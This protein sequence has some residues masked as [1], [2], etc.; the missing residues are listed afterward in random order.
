MVERPRLLELVE[1]GTKRPL[2]LIS[3]PAGSGKTVL[4]RAWIEAAE[5]PEKI[6]HVALGREHADRRTFWIDVMQAVSAARPE[7]AGLAVPAGGTRPLTDFLFELGRLESPLVIVLDDFHFV[8][9]GAVVSDIQWLLERHHPALRLVIATRHDPPL[10]LLRLRVAEEL[11]EIRGA[12]LAF[13]E[14]ETGELLAGVALASADV[15]TLWE[16]TEGWAAALK[17]A[18]LSLQTHPD[19][20]AFVE[21]FAGDDRAVTDYLTTEVLSSYDDEALGFLLRISIV[22]RINAELAEAL[23]GVADGQRSLRDLERADG[24]VDG[25]DSRGSWYRLHPLLAEV[26]RA[27]A[28]H[29]LADE[30]PALHTSASLWLADHGEPLE[31]VRHAVAAPDWQLAAE[32][33]GEQWL[34]CMLNG[35]G[36]SLRQLARQIPDD[37]VRADA[38]LALAMAGLL[39]EAGDIEHADELLLTAYEVAD[40]LSPTRSHRFNVTATATALYRARLDGDVDEALSAARLAL[41]ERWDRSV[42]AE[43]RA[44]TL[45]N[46][47]IAEFW[48]GNFDQAL[49]RL[50]AAAGLALEFGCDYVVLMA[51]SYLAA[52]DAREGRLS[53]AHS[54]A[55]TAIQLAD[56]RG[57]AEVPHVAVAHV[58]LA[59]VH[60]WWNELDEAEGAADRA[61]ETLGRSAEPLLAPLVAQLRARLCTM[62]GDA[63]TGLE[64]LRGGDRAPKLPEWLR[65]SGSFVEAELWLA[66]GEPG[67]ARRCLESVDS[68]GL[69][70]AAV[71]MA[72]LEL[73]R[74]E[75]E[76]ALR[77]IA[78]FL[79]DDREA[80]MPVTR[81]EAWTI[82]AIARDAIHDE[83]GA[84][85]AIERALDLAEPRGFTNSIIR[86]GPPV[87]S[88]LR[89]RIANGTAHRAFAAEILSVLEE[90]PG[91]QRPSAQPLL[92][93]LSERE[94]VVLRFLPTLMSNAEIAGEMF[95][96]VN[97]VKTHL[98]HIYRKLD[99]S[100]RREAVRRGRE[101]H[102]LSPGLGDQ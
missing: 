78:G 58:A 45:A 42:A 36:G 77:E 90:K 31:A 2:T 18:E 95:V 10:R 56:R 81:T 65:V 24:F 48:A 63:V 100:D 14:P 88:L 59:S 102:L 29:R 64:V 101:L 87:R 70:D 22:E 44:L 80:L 5:E 83:P 37:I 38:E 50:Q 84:L 35:L 46:L 91:S 61:R 4:L 15:Q 49:D 51:E 53:D 32:L 62:R 89:R 25:L 52:V 39:L 74:G 71:G 30:L 54:R 55:R 41:R 67:R 6:A 66:L 13:T 19:P 68:A 98:K 17:M 23:T 40:T 94:L 72:R 69:S 47:G 16:S 82:D 12:D 86:Y 73:A 9:S 21:G 43:V 93:P 3:A 57:W 75:P 20:H 92:E 8:G 7:L 76:A 33:I 34:R 60:L 96:S 1:E 99:V 85:R 79:V 28:R 11:A 97:T 26:L 27:E